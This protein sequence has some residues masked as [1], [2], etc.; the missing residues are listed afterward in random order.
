[1]TAISPEAQALIDRLHAVDLA[2]P[3]LDS[4][5]VENAFNRHLEALGLPLRPIRAMPDA[6]SA[7]RRMIGLADATSRLDATRAARETARSTWFNRELAA[8]NAA[9]GLALHISQGICTDD[10]YFAAQSAAN[11]ATAEA[12][13]DAG[14]RM[15]A[16]RIACHEVALKAEWVL[17]LLRAKWAASEAI[18]KAAGSR[19]DDDIWSAAYHTAVDDLGALTPALHA[20]DER[21]ALSAFA[22][23]AQQQLVDIWLPMLNAFEA[24][25]LCYWVTPPEVV[26]VSRPSLSI[27]DGN[28]HR[29]DGPAV[30][31]ATGE[32]YWFWRGTRVP[33]WVIE[34][35]S[36]ITPAVMRSEANEDVRRCMIERLGNERSSP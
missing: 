18:W 11:A 35:P 14:E 10:A 23:P 7:Y 26:W 28:L 30:E 27:V 17:A 19:T 13:G 4:E 15:N 25:L 9:H 24:G 6:S 16:A 2:R 8:R 36:R 21:N 12:A 3:K 29:E 32:R 34:D 31:W 5:A 20:C 1:M 33:Q 22:H